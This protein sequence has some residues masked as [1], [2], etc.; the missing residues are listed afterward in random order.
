MAGYLKL[1]AIEQSVFLC[2]CASP[3]RS[4][5]R[6]HVFPEIDRNHSRLAE[7]KKKGDKL[8]LKLK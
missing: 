8:L 2:R 1:P 7:K 4:A 6:H 3:R 5:P